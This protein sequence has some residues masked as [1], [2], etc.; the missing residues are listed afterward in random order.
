MVLVFVITCALYLGL[1]ESQR[2]ILFGDYCWLGVV[3]VA[4]GHRGSPRV[5]SLHALDARVLCTSCLPASVKLVT[6]LQ[7]F[8][9]W[10]VE[11]PFH[12]LFPT[13]GQLKL[14]RCSP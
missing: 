14:V 1:V 9:I 13:A 2:D 12:L 8:V 7:N 3:Y 10:Y 6:N 4:R 5:K 11:E